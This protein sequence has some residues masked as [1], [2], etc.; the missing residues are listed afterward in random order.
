MSEST[1]AIYD[2][3]K[4]EQLRRELQEEINKTT[5]S[6]RVE[7][8]RRKALYQK[9]EAE[10]ATLKMFKAAIKANNRLQYA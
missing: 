5:Y 3:P 9:D 6:P 10:K 7:A 1:K 2:H 4:T 8:E